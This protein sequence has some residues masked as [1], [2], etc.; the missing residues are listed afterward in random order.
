MAHIARWTPGHFAPG[1]RV[2]VT[3]QAWLPVRRV[4]VWSL[5]VPAG[6]LESGRTDADRD[7]RIHYHNVHGRRR[8][9]WQLD[10]P[11]GEPYPVELA[12]QVA[13]WHRLS[14]VARFGGH[15]AGTAGEIMHR[16][17]CWA[18]RLVLGL[19]G[20]ADDLEVRAFPT[21]A[22]V[23]DQ[24]RFYAACVDVYD[25]LEQGEPAERIRESLPP[26]P[27]DPAWRLPDHGH[28]DLP[29]PHV[30]PGD[31]VRGVW[32]QPSPG[33]AGRTR[34]DRTFCGPVTHTSHD[35]SLELTTIRVAPGSDRTVC[36]DVQLA[37]HQGACPQFAPDPE[38]DADGPVMV[39]AD[40]PPWGGT[41][42]DQ[43]GA[44]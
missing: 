27:I 40:G 17:V 32:V 44:R 21:P 11:D 6:Y 12:E 2:R 31:L 43:E 29:A 36:D 42:D 9:G 41:W 20:D 39:N 15:I 26:S 3:S 5:A 33:L 23:D 34:L 13:R 30:R 24:R 22:D 10:A 7:D 18:Q 38:E 16:H 14:N 28:V 1:D 8:D 4:E 37:V 19:P 35:V 25:R